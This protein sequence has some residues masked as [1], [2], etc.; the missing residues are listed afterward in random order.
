MFLG[1]GVGDL[2]IIHSVGI[3]YHLSEVV[4]GLINKETPGP[5]IKVVDQVLHMFLGPAEHHKVDDKEG[6]VEDKV[7]AAYQD[8]TRPD[9]K[10]S[11]T[12]PMPSNWPALSPPACQAVQPAGQGVTI[13]TTGLGRGVRDGNC[14]NKL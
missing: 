10:L 1:P 7:E 2:G 4:V 6:S 12:H 11:T 9:S 3:S 14:C 13:V 8:T 5:G